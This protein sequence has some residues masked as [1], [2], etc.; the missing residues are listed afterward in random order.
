M[1]D[2]GKDL[3]PLPLPVVTITGEYES[4]KTLAILTTGYPL[5]R[6]LIYD[7]EQ[8]SQT[9]EPLGDFQRV[10]LLSELSIEKP[11]WTNLDLY[12][13]WLEHMRAIEPGK[14]D[15]I[16]IDTVERLEAGIADWLARNPR[17]FGRSANQYQK[18]A[19]VY[20]ADV[21][22]LW[23]SHI[24]EL[25]AKAKMVI[26]TVHMRDQYSR[27]TKKPTG[28]RERKGKDTLSEMATLEITLV[29]KPGQVK[30]SAI[31]NKTRLVYGSLNDP[32]SVR[33][34][35]D[36]WIPEF[37]WEKIRWYMEHGADPDN[38]ILPPGPSEEELQAKEDERL[39]LKA[40]IAAAERAKIEAGLITPKEPGPT[41]FWKLVND[42]GFDKEK[43]RTI[44]QGGGTWAEKIAALS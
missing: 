25:T 37:T 41:E 7:M 9:Y 27:E 11:N 12:V 1:S 19:G 20:W 14:Y 33:P 43:A 34:M 30:P 28:K 32:A 29:R 13:K 31:V 39:R 8:S 15:V 35:F 36:K 21:K 2:N 10:D 3:F 38:P 24:L 18:M 6:T 26:L 17:H 42:S 16:G 4:G 44:A 5:K 22:A 40:E 23:G